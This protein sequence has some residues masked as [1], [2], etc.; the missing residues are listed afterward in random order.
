MLE[1][2]YDDAAGSRAEFNRNVLHVINR[3]LDAD[4]P[5]DSFDHHRLLR[6]SPEWIEMRLR[7]HVPA[8]S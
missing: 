1:A 3:E 4:F 6:P 2:A 8:R 5:V 7:A